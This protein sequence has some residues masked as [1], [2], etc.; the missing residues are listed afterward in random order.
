MISWLVIAALVILGLVFIKMRHI[1]HKFYLII[2]VFIILFVYI[3]ATKVLADQNLNF[4]SSSDI[5]K[6]VK[7]Y[8][9]W[10]GNVAGN[11]KD[12][13]ANA[14]KLDWKLNETSGA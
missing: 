13:A 2:L 1:K 11:F 14:I 8:F 12:I 4:K 10:L 9:S 3:T 7:L 6:A 5:G